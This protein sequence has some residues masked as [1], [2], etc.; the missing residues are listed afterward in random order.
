MLQAYNLGTLPLV[1]YL[2]DHSKFLLYIDI[3]IF[4]HYLTGELDALFEYCHFYYLSFVG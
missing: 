3:K 4:S 2:K 1:I